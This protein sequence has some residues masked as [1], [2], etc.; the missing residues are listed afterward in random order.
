MLERL[1]I[2]P[3]GTALWSVSRRAGGPSPRILIQAL[4]MSG[5]AALRGDRRVDR[6]Q[7]PG[8]PPVVADRYDSTVGEAVTDDRSLRRAAHASRTVAK[9]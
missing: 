6:K 8:R 3:G 2:L 1:P 7:R 4:R 9:P 5:R